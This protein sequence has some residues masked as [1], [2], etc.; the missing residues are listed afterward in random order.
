MSG[1]KSYIAKK[2]DISYRDLKDAQMKYYYTTYPELC[3]KYQLKPID[4]EIQPFEFDKAIQHLNKYYN[5]I[6]CDYYKNLLKETQKHNND[7]KKYSQQVADRIIF[8]YIKFRPNTFCLT[9]WPYAKKELTPLFGFLENYGHVYY[10]KSIQLNYNAALNLIYQLYSDTKRFPTIQKLQ[11]KLEYLGWKK[12]ETKTIRVV[13]F[14]NTSKEVISGSQAALK[15]K[16]RNELLKYSDNKNLRGD[17]LIHINDLFYQTIEYSK[18]YL[19]NNTLKFLKK[20]NLER[21]LD[22]K[23][24]SGRLYLNTVKSWFIDNI[25]LADYDRFLFFGS[26]VLYAYGLRNCRDVDG[27]VYGSEDMDTPNLVKKTAEFFHDRQTKFFFGSLGIMNTEYWKTEWNTKDEKW[28]KMMNVTHKDQL[29][30][31][32]EHHFYFNGI[33]LMTIKNETIRKFLRRKPQDYADMIEMQNI[34]H[35]TMNLPKIKDNKDSFLS[36]VKKSLESKYFISS[37]ESDKLIKLYNKF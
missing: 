24:D 12:D 23:L 2:Y 26:T 35:F 37:T 11:E 6:N 28:L 22:S 5:N 15:T 19:H 14:E 3:C 31:D 17:D 4:Y 29:I 16:I 13:F 30:F 21:L 8:E 18:I 7:I 9:I 36:E 20:Q 27:M 34:L 33:K 10:V 25:L 32:P 1:K